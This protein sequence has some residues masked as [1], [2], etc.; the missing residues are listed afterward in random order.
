MDDLLVVHGDGR[1]VHLVL[2]L[3]G[4]FARRDVEQRQGPEGTA[5][6]EQAQL[7]LVHPARRAVQHADPPVDLQS[8]EE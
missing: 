8:L 2:A 3:E 4:E 5:G 1:E 6:G 7:Q